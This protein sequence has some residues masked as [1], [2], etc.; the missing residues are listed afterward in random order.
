MSASLALPFMK[1]G[2]LKH[3]LLRQ[4]RLLATACDIGHEIFLIHM[5]SVWA[6]KRHVCFYR[7]TIVGQQ[8]CKLKLVKYLIVIS[9]IVV[10]SPLCNTPVLCSRIG[11]CMT[12]FSSHQA[13]GKI[14]SMLQEGFK[15]ST[16]LR[17]HFG[18]FSVVLQSMAVRSKVADQAL[19]QM[20]C[21][22]HRFRLCF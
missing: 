13:V 1:N 11:G 5:R 9:Y 22:P 21:V 12:E 8:I 3:C 7:G 10:L 16:G 17:L 14:W 6:R 4:D 15:S 2:I 18:P 19:S 20:S